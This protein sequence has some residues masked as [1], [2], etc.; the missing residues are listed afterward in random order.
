MNTN[1]IQTYGDNINESMKYVK[2]LQR[3]KKYKYKGVE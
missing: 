1:V 2:K 3:K